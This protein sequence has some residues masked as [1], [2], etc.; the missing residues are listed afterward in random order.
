MNLK[1]EFKADFCLHS[2]KINCSSKFLKPDLEMDVKLNYKT[3]LFT[4]FFA[5]LA[6][7][8][9]RRAATTRQIFNMVIKN[10]EFDDDLE[11][12]EITQKVRGPNP[13]AR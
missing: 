7:K 9:P 10:A 6:S 13:F 5:Y 4:P 3:H 2:E 1:P 8:F 12:V 11:S